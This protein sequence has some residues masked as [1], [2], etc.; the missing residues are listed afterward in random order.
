MKSLRPLSPPLRRLFLDRPLRAVLLG[1]LA[2]SLAGCG[3]EVDIEAPST[4]PSPKLESADSADSAPASAPPTQAVR[5]T[6]VAVS[7][8]TLRSGGVALDAP[9]ATALLGGYSTEPLSF[10]IMSGWVDNEKT[11]LT[12]QETDEASKGNKAMETFGTLTVQVAAAKA[13]PGTYQL[14]PKEGDPQTG[15]VIIDK[16]EGVGIASAYTSQS[17]TLTIKSVAMSDIGIL[18]AVDGS[19][20]GQFKSEEG[21]SRT[22]SGSF[23]LA[24]KN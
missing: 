23:R 16:A 8:I 17:G 22:F 7:G 2:V 18:A 21:D 24:A 6:A 4:T 19:F 14:A 11:M 9:A 20:D 5:Q 10:R 1:G 12:N 3:R 13:E 15:T